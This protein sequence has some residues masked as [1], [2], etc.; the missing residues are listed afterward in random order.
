MDWA[1]EHIMLV[2]PGKY[3]ISIISGLAKSK[4]KMGIGCIPDMGQSS[5]SV[6]QM[7]GWDCDHALFAH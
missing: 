4:R 7:Q 5:P 1:C 2:L 6:E 3:I